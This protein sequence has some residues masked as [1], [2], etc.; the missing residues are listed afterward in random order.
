MSH[1]RNVFIH[2]M[3]WKVNT[4]V[5]QKQI[6]LFFPHHSHAIQLNY[7]LIKIKENIVSKNVKTLS[8]SYIQSQSELVSY[9]YQSV[10]YI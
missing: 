1:T 3:L 2:G 5:N 8:Y 4:N 10:N 7:V 9:L 6:G